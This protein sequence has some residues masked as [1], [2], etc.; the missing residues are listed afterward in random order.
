MNINIQS[1]LIKE[2]CLNI[3][4]RVKFSYDSFR[5]GSIINFYRFV[6]RNNLFD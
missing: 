4:H 5:S 2:N 3:L 1:P 6:C